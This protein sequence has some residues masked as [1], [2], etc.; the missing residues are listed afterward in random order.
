MNSQTEN[1]DF[2]VLTIGYGGRAR[3]RSDCMST[4]RMAVDWGLLEVE[5]RE[6][7]EPMPPTAV[8]IHQRRNRM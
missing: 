8:P 7:S 4:H 1:R 2:G 5:V 6:V 3:E